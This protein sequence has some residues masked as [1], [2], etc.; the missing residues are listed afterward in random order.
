VRSADGRYRF[1]MQNDGNVVIY[2]DGQAIWDTGTAG[3]TQLSASCGRWR[4]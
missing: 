2:S 1:V 3:R 4:V